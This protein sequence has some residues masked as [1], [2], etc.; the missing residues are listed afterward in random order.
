MPAVELFDSRDSADAEPLMT[1]LG[2][3]VV[4]TSFSASTVAAMG[5]ATPLESRD[6]LFPLSQ[7]PLEPSVPSK[8][9]P[10]L[11]DVPSA[12]T[13]NM[14]QSSSSLSGDSMIPCLTPPAPK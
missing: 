1:I 14:R 4:Q 8:L 9:P 11:D 13:N 2:Q 12:A 7:E 3:P 6:K 10:V 5:P